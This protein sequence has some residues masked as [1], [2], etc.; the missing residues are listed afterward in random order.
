MVQIPASCV[1]GTY[2]DMTLELCVGCPAGSVCAGGASQARPCPRGGFCVAGEGEGPGEEG[3]GVGGVERVSSLKCRSAV[4]C[5]G[6]GAGRVAASGTIS[7]RPTCR[8]LST[9]R[10]FRSRFQRLKSDRFNNLHA[11][12]DLQPYKQMARLA[13]AGTA[14]PT[15]KEVCLRQKQLK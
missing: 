4:T 8:K 1:P 11:A 5:E 2:L 9:R 13:L 10:I 3:Q 14:E 6:A 12:L 15:K 7:R